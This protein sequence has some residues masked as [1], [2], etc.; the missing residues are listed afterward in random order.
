MV[1]LE[2]IFWQERQAHEVKESKAASQDSL[3]GVHEVVFLNDS[4]SKSCGV[5]YMACY[6]IFMDLNS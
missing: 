3:C 5:T 2:A 6:D 1:L 4:I